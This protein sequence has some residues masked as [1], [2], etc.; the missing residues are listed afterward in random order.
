MKELEECKF[1]FYDFVSF[2]WEGLIKTVTH[3][4]RVGL[5]SVSHRSYGGGPTRYRAVLIHGKL[6]SR[7]R[8][9]ALSERPLIKAMKKITGS[10]TSTLDKIET[11]PMAYNAVMMARRGLALHRCLHGGL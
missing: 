4:Q 3:S 1:L 10:T 5:E 2:Q 6:I 9:R 11:L 7:E 8:P